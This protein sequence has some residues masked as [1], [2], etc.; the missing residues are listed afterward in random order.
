MAHILV[1]EDS[2]ETAGEIV[3][4]LERHG[5]DVEHVG[6]GKLAFA[7]IKDER[8]DAITLDRM[9]PGMD[10]LSFLARLRAQQIRTPVLMI[11]AMS[12][13]DDR[14]AGLRAGGDDYMVKPFSP[15]EMA[16]RIEVLLRRQ[17]EFPDDGVLRVGAL[18]IDLIKRRVWLHGEPIQ[19]LNKEFRLLEFLA[20]HHGELVGRQIIF[21]QVWGYFFEP[22]DNL[23][24]VHM[25][26]LR[27]KLEL[28]G[29][30]SP[31]QTIKGQGYRL[32][33]V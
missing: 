21:E 30:P 4:E 22:N 11:S 27:K 7:R 14:I 32:V 2:P 18:E 20:R 9:L 29:R 25:G 8:F 5:H 24:N 16:V 13:V 15:S 3:A 17:R 33:E 23:I 31:I 10:G 12:D 19:L 1:I 28:S 6:D 26:K